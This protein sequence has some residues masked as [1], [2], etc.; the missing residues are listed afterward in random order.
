[1]Q[2]QKANRLTTK[3][4]SSTTAEGKNSKYTDV[5]AKR[6]EGL[7]CDGSAEI[8][9]LWELRPSKALV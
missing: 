3:I 5:N 1:M 2:Q 9:V 7:M 6:V 4:N 8:N